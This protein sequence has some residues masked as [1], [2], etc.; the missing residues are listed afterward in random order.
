MVSLLDKL[1]VALGLRA[2]PP[3]KPPPYD[4]EELM[5]IYAETAAEL[6]ELRRARPEKRRVA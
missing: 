5:R 1:L 3:P 2:P 6:D 4:G